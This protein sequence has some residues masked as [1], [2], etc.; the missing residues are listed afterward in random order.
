M[1]ESIL[2]VNNLVVG[3]SMYQPRSFHKTTLQVIHSLSLEV[4]KGEILAVVGSSGS[5]KSILAHAVLN[6]LPKNAVVGGEVLY[7]GQTITK[8]REKELFGREIAFIP[9]SIDYLDPVMKVGKQVEGVFG[10]SKRK[11]ELF[12]QYKLPIDTSN[13]YPFQLSGGM[14][15]R[16]LICG[17]LM[18]NPELII[19]DEPT[20]G[21]SLDIAMETL[22]HFRTFADNG[23][24]VLMITHDI[25]LALN[26]ADKVAVFYAGSII[27][28]AP[29]QDFI[30]GKDALR[31]PYSKALI[32]ALPQNEFVP[33][34]GTQPYAGDLPSGCLFAK[35][36]KYRNENCVGRQEERE[37]RGGKVRC[38]NAV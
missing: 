3:F 34:L 17:A 19:A 4:N 29:T 31:H 33:I 12:N 16:I 28:I 1:S 14:A 20:P 24:G 21:L 8:K 30:K 36:C 15:R 26:V 6:L 7:K 11:E 37:L 32:D 5:G 22:Q 27:E 25:D 23:T 13:K 2:K 18:G 10:T 35:R 9:Q 38:I